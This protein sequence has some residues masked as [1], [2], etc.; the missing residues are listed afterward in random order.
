MENS[1][2]LRRRTSRNTRESTPDPNRSER[3][4]KTFENDTKNRSSHELDANE[5]KYIVR[6]ILNVGPPS[7]AGSLSS[8]SSGSA[9]NSLASNSGSHAYR[10]KL[11][12]YL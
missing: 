7:P 1:S 9:S 5:S 4:S 10:A 2:S 8:S 11:I 3:L 6:G 12:R